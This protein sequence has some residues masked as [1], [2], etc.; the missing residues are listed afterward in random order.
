MLPIVDIDECEQGIARCHQGCRNT[1]EG[2]ICTCNEGYQNHHSDPSYCVG[3]RTSVNYN[4]KYEKG[5]HA[6]SVCL[7]VCYVCLHVHVYVCGTCIYVCVF[8]CVC[9]YVSICMCL[10]LYILC[11]YVPV[12]YNFCF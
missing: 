12:S 8:V 3:M 4:Y 2:F 7:S 1:D 5:T 9:V 10:C 11:P 6:L